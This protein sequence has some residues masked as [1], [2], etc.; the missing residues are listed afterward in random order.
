MEEKLR[1]TLRLLI[2]LE[3]KRSGLQEALSPEDWHHLANLLTWGEDR[4]VTILSRV[5]KGEAFWPHDLAAVTRQLEEE[6][7]TIKGVTDVL[8]DVK[9][10]ADPGPLRG[11]QIAR[12]RQPDA[13]PDR[14]ARPQPLS[15]QQKDIINRIIRASQ[16]VRTGR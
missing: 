10:A 3:D 14:D 2:D 9:E 16:I 7:L 13:T 6:V 8:G 11:P 15:Q 5:E 1:R 12:V 4:L